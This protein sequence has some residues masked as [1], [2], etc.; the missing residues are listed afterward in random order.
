ME[1]W[2]KDY[3]APHVI[4]AETNRFKYRGNIQNYQYLESMTNA[5]K[6]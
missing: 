6:T 5:R 4:E 1:G 3:F 2:P